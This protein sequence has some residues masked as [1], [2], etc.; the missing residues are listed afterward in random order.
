MSQSKFIGPIS[1]GLLALA[2]VGA[3]I[4][5]GRD[6]I[7]GGLGLLTLIDGLMAFLTLR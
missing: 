6:Q 3:A 7:V 1:I 5:G 4:D 2:W